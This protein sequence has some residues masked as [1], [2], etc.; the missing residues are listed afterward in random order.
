[1]GRAR[2]V[3]ITLE[4][5][6]EMVARADIALEVHVIAESVRQLGDLMLGRA[7][8]ERAGVKGVVDRR[9]DPG[10]FEG[11][12]R[13][14]RARHETAGPGERGGD[15]RRPC[16]EGDASQARR[17]PMLTG[18]DEIDGLAGPELTRVIDAGDGG[19]GRARVSAAGA[20]ARQ[21]PREP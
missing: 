16:A 8:G 10:D 1:Y 2:A 6:L 14:Q 11:E 20:G 17:S 7:M 12:R 15:R 5:Q 18:K 3:D 4:H 9:R 13:L 21:Q 19:E